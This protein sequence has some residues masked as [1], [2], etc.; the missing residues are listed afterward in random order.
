[1]KLAYDLVRV[2]WRVSLLIFVLVILSG[3]AE[4][5]GLLGIFQ[6]LIVGT[7]DQ[8]GS[9]LAETTNSVLSSLH[10]PQS[11]PAMLLILMV[12]LFLK[13][14]ILMAS[15]WVVSHVVQ[16]IAFDLQNRIIGSISK[17]ELAHIQ[18]Q[19]VGAVSNAVNVE[20]ARSSGIYDAVIQV[21][22]GT[23]I[24]I[25]YLC[26]SVAVSPQ[27]TL[28]AMLVGIVVVLLGTTLVR[29]SKKISIKVTNDQRLLNSRLVTGFSDLKPLKAMNRQDDLSLELTGIATEL[30]D[31]KRRF[32]FMKSL[33]DTS[34]EPITAFLICTLAIFGYSMNI[35]TVSEILFV[36]ILAQRTSANF[37]QVQLQYQRIVTNVWA[38]ESARGFIVKAT[39]KQEK[40]RGNKMPDNEPAIRFED[41]DFSRGEKSVLN[42]ISADIEFGQLV[43]IMGHSGAGKT[44][45]LDLVAGLYPVGG[46]Q[47][48]VGRQP[49]EELDFG[50]WRDRIGYIPQEYLLYNDTI[51]NNIT[52]GDNSIDDGLVWECLRQAGA[53]TF[54]SEKP[55][56]LDYVV[57]EKGGL[58]S[59]GQR[60]RLSI[61]RALIRKPEIMLLDEPTAALDD[62]S[63]EQ[64]VA[65]LEALKGKVTMLAVTHRPRLAE[66]A[67]VV[68]ELADGELKRD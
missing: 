56:Q 35:V 50:A 52:L 53:D 61:A 48:Q 3:F 20:A 23:V 19:S 54:V 26:L 38:L 7:G 24:G 49:L 4:G 42:N 32:M 67:D 13:F 64:L 11:F 2:R 60:Q 55:E 43:V 51:R 46:G 22:A 29:I 18:N 45:L 33:L 47:I 14:I 57:G 63:E 58:L 12:F 37:S 59:G 25:F 16:D 9:L 41:V 36:A 68:Y 21:A 40:W 30:R 17:S 8:E 34:R 31:N 44:T 1:M 62:R 15:R 6:I 66:I 10:I 39:E 5:I 65:T 28:A 27:A